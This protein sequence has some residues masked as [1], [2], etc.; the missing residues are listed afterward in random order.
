MIDLS[1]QTVF[2]LGGGPSLLK[3]LGELEEHIVDKKI[4][5]RRIIAINESIYCALYADLLFFRDIAWYFA[6]REI[7]EAWNGVVVSSTKSD[8]YGD[9]INIVKTKHCND[10]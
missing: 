6:N 8:F 2:L 4:R 10:F 9:K 7:V 3:S 1:N 5:K